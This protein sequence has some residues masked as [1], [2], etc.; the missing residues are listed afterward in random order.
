[1]MLDCRRRGAKRRLQLSFTEQNIEAQVRAILREHSGLR[2][3]VQSIGVHESLWQRGM[4]SLASVDV[5]V[6]LESTFDFEFPDS[7][8]RHATFGT[9][10]NIM[11]CVNA[12]TESAVR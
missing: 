3:T 1:M 8:L 7:W 4:T 2:D 5:M 9:I 6:A 10:F 12:L 11:G